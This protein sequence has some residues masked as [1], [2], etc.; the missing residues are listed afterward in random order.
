MQMS[1]ERNFELVLKIDGKNLP[2]LKINMSDEE[3]Y[4]AAEKKIN[5]R[6]TQYRMAFGGNPEVNDW[7]IMAMITVQALSKSYFLEDK[8]NTKPFEDKIDSL[9]GELDDYLKR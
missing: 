7:D 8:N 4:R 6:I 9:I 5:E 3:A 2:R 1:N